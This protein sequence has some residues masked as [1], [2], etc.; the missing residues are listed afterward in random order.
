MC[1]IAGS[2]DLERGLEPAAM[3]AAMTDVLRHRGPDDAGLLADGPVTFGH[4]RLAII[5]LTPAGHQPMPSKDESLWITYNGEI[6]NYLEL[7]D[8]LQALGHICVTASDTEVLLLAYAEWGISMLER[9]NGMFAFA[10]W[11]RRTS[12][13]ILA[14]DRFGVKP[15]YY[16]VAAGRLR[17]A[18][19]IKA[20]LVDPDVPRSPNDARVLDFLAYGLSDHTDETL[21]AGVLQVPPGS[22]LRVKPYTPLPSPVRWYSLRPAGQNGAPAGARIRSR[23]DQAV[24]L[25]LRSDVPVGVSL[26]GGLDSSSVLCVASALCSASGLE[27]PQSFSARS[28]DPATDEYAYS[29]RVIASTGSANTQ[30]LPTFTGLV[31][32]LDSLIWQMDEPFHSPSVYGQRKVDELARNAGVVV[33]LDGQGG[34]EVLSGYHHF[35]YPP[36]LLSLLRRGKISA[37]V[38]EVRA[39]HRRVGTSPLR[40]V[41]DVARLLLAPYRR[42]VG[43]PDW[44]APGV[45]VADR[46]RPSSSLESHQDY[47]LAIAPLPAYNHHA[48]RN[49]MTFSLETRN[50]LLDVHLVEAARALTG[51]ELLHDGFTKW[52]LREAVRDLLPAEVVNRARKQGFTTDEAHWLRAGL[53]RDF[54]ETFSSKSFAR[55]GYCDPTKVLEALAEHEAGGNRAAELWRAYVAERWLRLFIDPAMLQAP[56][57]PASA[58]ASAVAAIDNMVSPREGVTTA[59]ESTAPRAG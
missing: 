19:E 40:S 57:P 14:R 38:R 7:R 22:Y 9:L 39:R 20:L 28:S 52:A 31:D 47:G 54:E 4:R 43:L 6:Y 17:F 50:P 16:T 42:G 3:V 36:L 8:E 26:S 48:D 58:V 33:L 23:L 21:F 11:D 46:P 25:R 51:E 49:S 27:A 37:F 29:E 18:S 1:G 41:K 32:D 44:L 55:R 10:I 2:V 45:E 30:V 56:A 13:V 35:H 53:N 5:D 15:L 59:T 24:L 34:D 12:S